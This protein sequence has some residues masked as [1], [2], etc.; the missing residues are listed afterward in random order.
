MGAICIVRLLRHTI[1]RCR[2]PRVGGR[3]ARGQGGYQECLFPCGAIT[4][5]T[6]LDD[7]LK[8]QRL[9][10][11]TRRILEEN[12]AY[13]KAGGH[14]PDM[15]YAQP[16]GPFGDMAGCFSPWDPGPKMSELALEKT[17]GFLLPVSG[18]T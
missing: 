10:G 15:S 1:R 4:H 3:P 6:V 7:I 11:Q 14:G 2:R 9:D 12:I 18:L 17:P 8:D 13:A 5:M 16:T